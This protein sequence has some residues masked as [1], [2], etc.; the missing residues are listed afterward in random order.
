MAGLKTIPINGGFVPA[1]M[2]GGMALAKWGRYKPLHFIAFGLITIGY[3]SVS[4]LGVNSSVVTWVCL[5]LILAI[6]L[7]FAAGILLPAMQAM[8]DESLVALTVGV[9]SFGRGFGCIWGVTIPSAVFNNQ[10]A[11]NARTMLDDKE[12]LQLLAEGRG[13]ESATKI[14]LDSIGNSTSR[15]QVIE[16]FSQV[17]AKEP[18]YIPILGRFSHVLSRLSLLDSNINFLQVLAHCL[19]CGSWRRGFG[20][21]N[22][23]RGTGDLF[24]R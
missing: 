20:I 6:G 11:V 24:E 13:Y 3:G 22:N 7:G 5:Q 12:L 17:S 15:S 14:F 19:V 21:F 2:V 10:V 23:F 9:W 8:L 1:A 4:T 18:S 16:V